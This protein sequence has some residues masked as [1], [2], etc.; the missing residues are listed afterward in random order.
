MLTIPSGNIPANGFY[1]I[2]NY[3]AISASSTLA[4]T[5][6]LVTTS[7]N[8]SNT[9][10]QVKLYN[11]TFN[12]GATLID[13][14]GN[15]STPLAGSNGTPKAS[16]SR[17]SPAG[18]GT[19]A[20]SWYT[21]DFGTG[22]DTGAMELGTPGVSNTGPFADLSV[23]KNANTNSV[24]IGQTVAFTVNYNNAG[25][26]AASGV[27]VTDDY[28]QTRMTISNLNGNCNNNGDTIVCTVGT[29][30]NGGSGSFTYTGTA[31]A[32]GTATNTVLITSTTSDPAPAN[33]T[34][35]VNVNIGASA[36]LSLTKLAD[37]SSAIV[38]EMVTYT[39][40]Y[41][42]A[43]PNSAAPVTIVDDY[44]QTRLNL[45][46]NSLPAGCSSNGNTITCT[47]ASLANGGNGS[48]SYNGL[49]SALG[50]ATNTAVISSSGS[51]DPAPANNT[52]FVNVTIA[53]G[54]ADLAITKNANV[55]SV[56]RGNSVVYTVNYQNN[57][58]TAALNVR[59]LDDYDDENLSVSGFPGQCIDEVTVS[60]KRLNCNF[61]TLASG[62]SGSFTYTANTAAAVRGDVRNIASISS[63]SST[64]DPNA[65]NNTA[66]FALKILK[67]PVAGDFIV[68]EIMWMGSSVGAND[69][70]FELRNATSFYMDVS[71]F[72]TTHL[73]SSV[74]TLLA[75]VPAST[76]LNPYQ[77][78]LVSRFGVGASSSLNVTP[79]QIVGSLVL[80][81]TNLQ[82]K[83]YN[84]PFASSTLLDTADDGAGAPLAGSNGTPKASMARMW[85]VGNGTVSASWMTSILGE[86]SGFTLAATDRGTPG[87]GNFTKL[88]VASNKNGGTTV[89]LH[90]QFGEQ[91]TLFSAFKATT[92]DGVNLS[93]GD[94]DHDGSVEIGMSKN[95]GGNQVIQ[96]EFEGSRLLVGTRDYI[97][98]N[99]NSNG[100]NIAGC[101]F[102]GTGFKDY[103][104]FGKKT[105]GNQV[106]IYKTDGTFVRQFTG[107]T[108]GSGV[109]IACGDF[110]GDGKDEI[111]VGKESGGNEV[112]QYTATG[113]RIRFWTAFSTGS[114]VNVATGDIDG[115][116]R[117]EVIVG[118]KTGGQEVVLFEEN[119]TYIRYFSAWTPSGTGTRVSALDFDGD[120]QAEI[121]TARETGDARLQLFKANGTYLKI[122]NGV[123]GAD[124]MNV[125]GGKFLIN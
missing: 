125:S 10:L 90:N 20:S 55:N 44:D 87:V 82:L 3:A 12:N 15:N 56:V 110:T 54:S 32:S 49:A 13:T 89:N 94:F 112:V 114:G 1:L 67:A 96:D 18:N 74:E 111:V 11:G 46:T 35:S 29:L 57:G 6:N 7:V 59:I 75:T 47:V 86:T 80:E 103:L 45:N 123:T 88:I 70:W 34:A 53:T 119:G 37:K 9:E 28:D 124:G 30:A 39:L 65:A 58:P 97:P 85:N 121:I 16:M 73:V 52:A 66:T 91:I 4:V 76:V 24:N 101:D 104:A 68:S 42:N 48:I 51:S 116:G 117:A 79:D 38:G 21:S 77:H 60:G 98:V 122:I 25:P 99:S 84:G 2:S 83:V 26:S 19:I 33:N 95:S 72:Q 105:G 14:A 113:T 27:V 69:Q 62:G 78:Y 109:T 108:V 81:T 63:S 64:A 5:P 41:S 106:I 100:L 40:N 71:G 115:D 22:F 92:A 118:K 61:G 23:S 102:D 107:F 36:D 120:G 93:T 31:T 8:L 17:N 43:G 50:T